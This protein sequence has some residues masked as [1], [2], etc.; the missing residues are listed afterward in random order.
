[1]TYWHSLGVIFMIGVVVFFVLAFFVDR[2]D[3]NQ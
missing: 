1:M 2:N 3:P